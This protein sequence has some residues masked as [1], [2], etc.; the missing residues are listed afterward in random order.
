MTCLVTGLGVRA[1]ETR[2]A[3]GLASLWKDPTFQKQFMGT[4]AKVTEHEP[5]VSPEESEQM[6]EVIRLMGNNDN[7]E[8]ARKKLEAVTKPGSSAALHFTLGNIY[9]QRGDHA[10]ASERYQIAVRQFDRFRRAHKNLGLCQVQASLWNEAILSFTRTIELGGG[11]G[12]TY[13]LLG[14]SYAS[15]EAYVS[16]ESAYRNAVLLQ[17]DSLQWKSGLANCLTKQQKFGEAAKLYAE[18]IVTAPDE[19]K[20]WISQASC[21]LGAREPLKAAAN[22]EMLARMDKATIET[23]NT[24]GDIYVNENLLD[25]AFGAYRRG[26]E[27]N[28]QQSPEKPLRAGEILASRGALP[29][30]KQIVERTRE[31]MGNRLEEADRKKLLK[32][33]ARIAIAEGGGAD[34]ARV[35]EEIVSLDPLDGEALLLLGQHHVRN[36]NPERAA[37]YYERAASIESFEADAKVRHAQLLVTQ[38]KFQDAVPLLRRAQEI[39]PRDS[40]ARYLDQVER[41]AKSKR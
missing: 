28:P 18:M 32:L 37:F 36:K 8:A 33:E 27:I 38:Q 20:L 26:L 12:Y 21:Y 23:L 40:V 17:P 11:D 2:S 29:Q 13:G 15:I 4:Y 10:R 39:K 1:A 14:L 35:L 6:Q 31:L 22:F 5:P 16:A 30:A 7:M 41:I 24:L 3:D 25:L 19:P 9:F 34:A